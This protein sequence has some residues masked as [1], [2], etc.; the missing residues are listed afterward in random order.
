MVL[1]NAIDRIFTVYILYA[2]ILLFPQGIMGQKT[3]EV[4]GSYV[5]QV[6][7]DANITLREAKLKCIE[8][9]KAEAIK[10]EFGEM[11][12]SEAID[13]NIE[14]NG[15]SLSSFFWENTVALA[16]GD[17]LGDLQKP[18]VDIVYN[19][20]KLVFRA[21]VWGMAREIIQSKTEL[22]WNIMKDG[23]E[24]KVETASFDSGEKIY[25]SFRSPA[26]GYVAIYL[27]TG[28][29]QTACLLPYKKNVAGRFPVKGDTD[30]VFFDKALSPIAQQY[31]L[32]TN[33]IKEQNQIVIMFSPNPFTKC[34]DITGDKTHP[35]SLSTHDF[36]KWLLK[37]QRSDRDLVVNKKWVTIQNLNAVKQ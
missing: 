10:K 28:E 13:T 36:Q 37:I 20:G 8:L 7:D 29:D 16:R 33:S 12:T 1:N 24:K 4:H 18:K 5:Y 3:V 23:S 11:I 35:N 31:A 15:E 2:L 26:D 34:N 25:V 19:E 17:W 22:K 9:A 21:E 32:S 14:T 27:I 30:Y 6:N